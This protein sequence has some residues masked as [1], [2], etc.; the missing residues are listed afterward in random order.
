MNTIRIIAD[1]REPW[2]HPWERWLPENCIL[3]RDTLDTGDFAL[4]AV[5]DGAV[6]ER[7]TA[8]DIAGCLT[9]NRTRFERELR[10]SRHLGAF[11]VVIES[12]LASVAR[13]ARGMHINAVLG[14][15]AAWTRRYCPFVF[16]GSTA[17]AADFSFRFLLGQIREMEKAQEQVEASNA[18]T[19]PTLRTPSRA[20]DRQKSE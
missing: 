4:H 18:D 16:A 3:L 14:T 20:R 10:R 6:I 19:I 9:S 11:A 12:D 8:S 13:E 7:K 2:P 15:L 17:A 1:T 5:P